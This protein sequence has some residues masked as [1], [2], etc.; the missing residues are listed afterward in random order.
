M[1]AFFNPPAQ[2]SGTLIEPHGLR[3][4]AGDF[5]ASLGGIVQSVIWD[6]DQRGCVLVARQ[7]DFA[8]LPQLGQ[9]MPPSLLQTGEEQVRS[10]QQQDFRRGGVPARQRSEILVDDCLKERGDDLLYRDPGFQQRVGIRFGKDPTLAA[11]LMQCVSGVP[12]LGEL[13]RWNF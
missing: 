3:L 13:L 1:L 11:D 9:V 6:S 2:F 7:L 8:L 10:P 4:P 12:H 5:D